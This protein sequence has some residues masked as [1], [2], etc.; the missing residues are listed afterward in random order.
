M[1]VT[2]AGSIST[3]S[4][5][6]AHISVE[7]GGVITVPVRFTPPVSGTK[8]GVITIISNDPDE[9]SRTVS[10]Q[11]KGIEPLVPD[12]HVWPLSIDF[13]ET[14]VG[15]WLDH[16]QLSQQGVTAIVG[17]FLLIVKI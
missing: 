7:P 12:I 1:F 16:P 2:N 11:G 9:P 4:S 13:G 5:G 17:L 6:G 3:V 8:T 15:V 14:D 10:V